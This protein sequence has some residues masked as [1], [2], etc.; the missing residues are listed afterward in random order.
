M[1]LNLEHGLGCA[2][3]YKPIFDYLLECGLTDIIEY[4]MHPSDLRKE[5]PEEFQ[6]TL[7]AT[8]DTLFG[9]PK[10]VQQTSVNYPTRTWRTLMQVFDI[11]LRIPTR[12][13][14]L[15]SETP[16]ISGRYITL[17]MKVTD[18]PRETFESYLPYL[19]SILQSSR[20][21]IVLTGERELTPCREYEIHRDSMF[22]MYPYIRDKL[23]LAIDKT[24]AET[25]VA[26]TIE[27][28]RGSANLYQFA[29][30]NVL[31]NSSGGLSLVAVFGKMIALTTY[32][33]STVVVMEL[34]NSLI[35]HS[36]ESFIRHFAVACR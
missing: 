13:P 15:E 24:Y 29:T 1:K 17:N 19:L 6:T 8:V 26:N 2:I 5:Y 23:P 20:Y 25:K 12:I 31:L 28:L 3:V 16:C 30:H 33:C 34:K 32:H 21:P 11:P 22:S 4:T 9:N 7:L 10:I 27:T 18:V 14:A 36:M 35:T